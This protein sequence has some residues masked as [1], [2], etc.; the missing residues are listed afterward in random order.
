M[1]I[2]NK[3]ILSIEISTELQSV[4]IKYKKYIFTK[5]KKTKKN[6][7][8]NILILIKKIIQKN[9]INFKK[10]NYFLINN[11]PGNILNSNLSLNIAQTFFLKYKNIKLIKTN[12]FN[13]INEKIKIKYTKKKKYYFIIF[14]SIKNIYISYIKNHNIIYNKKISLNKIIKKINSTKKEIITHKYKSKK[15]ILNLMNKK[16]K[17]KIIYPQAKYMIYF[18]NKKN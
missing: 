1:N 2:K 6:N 4:A 9:N 7:N 14:N 12:T 8:Q 17:I 11:D 15:K 10:I 3:N 18:I 16:K 5:K 13:I